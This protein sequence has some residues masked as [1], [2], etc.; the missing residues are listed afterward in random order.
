MKEIT[1]VISKGVAGGAVVALAF[2]L[3]NGE[4]SGADIA[5]TLSA[6]G[7]ASGVAH[8]WPAARQGE[9]R[10]ESASS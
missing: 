10:N 9:E 8:W 7:V 4:I 2:F 6:G 5:I 3:I 1:I